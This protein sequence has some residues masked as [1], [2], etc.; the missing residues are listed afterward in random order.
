MRKLFLIL[1]VCCGLGNVQIYFRDVENLI[2][3]HAF[4]MLFFFFFFVCVRA[5]VVEE[6]KRNF[7]GVLEEGEV[8]N[9]N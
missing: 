6:R 8:G 2:F 7:S 1:H 5:R 4:V 3:Q 9:G